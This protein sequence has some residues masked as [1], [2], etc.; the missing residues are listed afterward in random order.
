[1][2]RVSNTWGFVVLGNIMLIRFL[3]LSGP[4][5]S[6]QCLQPGLDIGDLLFSQGIF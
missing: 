1:M 6:T 4:E 2:L 3:V 5:E